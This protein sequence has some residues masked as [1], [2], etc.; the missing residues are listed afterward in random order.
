[1]SALA[2]PWLVL[3]TT[4]SASR[5]GLVVFAE[6]TPYVVLQAISGPWV[7]RAGAHRSATWG[8]AAAAAAVGAIP[9]LQAANL[10]SIGALLSLVAAAGAVRGLADC[11]N[12]ARPG[13]RD[14]GRGAAGARRRSEQRRR[15]S[16][17]PAR[18]TPCRRVAGVVDPATVVLIDAVTLFAAAVLIGALVPVSAQPDPVATD[19][20]DRPR[21]L[22][23]L[24]EGLRF[25]RADRLILALATMIAVTNLLDYA[26]FSVLRPV[27][28]RD[29]LGAVG[30]LGPVFRAG[31]VGSLLGTC[32][33]MGRPAA[34]P[35]S[36]LR[37]RLPARRRAA[38]RGAGREL[39]LVAPAARRV[40]RG[41]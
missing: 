38:V 30:A 26:L 32:S 15:A 19:G 31:G 18:R 16:R 2:I 5:T 6:M 12:T 22:A 21:Y 20:A 4:G 28:V 14:S 11:A 1:M 7:D 35:S 9:V 29:R 17:L 27:W 37:D 40:R 23:Q 8:N 25:V 41:A 24:V 36:H 33:A 39:H 3:T 13:Y 34:A 10:L